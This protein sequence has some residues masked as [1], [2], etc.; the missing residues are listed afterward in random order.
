M[1]A[2]ARMLSKLIS[3]SGLEDQTASVIFFRSAL[4][5][6]GPLNASLSMRNLRGFNLGPTE[7]VSLLPCFERIVSPRAIRGSI[8][9]GL[10]SDVG[11][12]SMYGALANSLIL[13]AYYPLFSVNDYR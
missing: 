6:D 7:D 5:R 2:L 8:L 13:F 4:H 11:P 1:D 3:V 10:L 12:F 9:G